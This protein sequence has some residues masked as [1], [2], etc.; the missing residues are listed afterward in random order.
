MLFRSSHC[1]WLGDDFGDDS[2]LYLT[3]SLLVAVSNWGNM[4]Y[5]TNTTVRYATDPGGIFQTVGAG[6][7]YLANNSTNR[8]AGTTNLNT[9]LV[10]ALRQKTTYPLVLLSNVTLTAST[11]L[12]PQV[13]RDTDTP[14]LGFHYYPLDFIVAQCVVTNATLTLSNGVALGYFNRS[15]GIWLQDNSAINSVGS[16]LSPNW[17]AHYTLVQE[18]PVFIGDVPM[19]SAQ[20]VNSYHYG[21]TGPEGQYRFTHFS[22]PGGAYGLY[23]IGRASCRERV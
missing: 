12:L 19:T 16:P 10:A 17:F 4:T 5:T 13:A 1:N 2:A 23:Q 8:N 20:A 22:C 18:Q 3:N 9:D 7:F 14:D 11:N 6:A 21:D 15:G